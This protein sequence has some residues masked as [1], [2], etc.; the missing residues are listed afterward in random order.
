MALF[1]SQDDYRDWDL[2][3]LSDISEKK[4][5][6]WEFCHWPRSTNAIP[7]SIMFYSNANCKKRKLSHMHIFLILKVPFQDLRE[8]IAIFKNYSLRL[9]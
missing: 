1:W 8:R 5:T 4:R 2:S 6:I 9:N 7:S 3:V